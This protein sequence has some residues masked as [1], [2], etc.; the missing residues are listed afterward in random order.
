VL[1]PDQSKSILSIMTQS[2]LDRPELVTIPEAKRRTGLGL[3]QFRRGIAD[4]SLA[5]S[6]L[7]GWPRVRWSEVLAWIEGTRRASADRP[8]DTHHARERA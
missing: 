6:D 2:K 3:R 8:L 7:G 1:P 4:G 5:V